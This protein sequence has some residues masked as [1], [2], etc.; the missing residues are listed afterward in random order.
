MSISM[1]DIC[2][3]MVS[4]YKVEDIKSNI[5]PHSPSF[6]RVAKNL[7]PAGAVSQTELPS[8]SGGKRILHMHAHPQMMYLMPGGPYGVRIG[9]CF[10]G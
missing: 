6:S 10:G 4:Y 5:F 3:H 7:R 2:H 1:N 8:A 9:Q